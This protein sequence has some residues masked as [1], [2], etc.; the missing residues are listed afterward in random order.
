[1]TAL[2]DV[3]SAASGTITQPDPAPEW[4]DLEDAKK[5]YLLGH[6]PTEPTVVLSGDVY[7]P[8]V[9]SKGYRR[10]RVYWGQGPLDRLTDVLASELGRLRALRY[11]WDGG[12]ARPTT[13]KALYAAMRVLSVLLDEE[14]EPPQFF[15]LVDGGIQL[16]WY[17]NDQVEIEID[18]SGEAYVL[19]TAANGEEF[20]GVLDPSGPSDLV[21]A[22][23][24]LVKNL[25]AD[26]A[27]ERRLP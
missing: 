16:Q 3:R 15:P 18:N 6:E 14:S 8:V 26:V 17:A 24:M 19:A 13:P 11:G 2:N 25:S 22:I 23:A 4:P 5:F 10:V 27:A 1:M 20:E 7:W 21:S 9:Q 12:S